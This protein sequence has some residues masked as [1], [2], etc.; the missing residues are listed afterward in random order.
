MGSLPVVSIQR[1][2]GGRLA[3]QLVVPDDLDLQFI[4]RAALSIYW[5]PACLQLEDLYEAETSVRASFQRI[6]GAL[7]SEY[8]LTLERGPHLRW[9][10][11]SNS[12]RIA[13]EAEWSA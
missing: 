5:N 9:E 8:G 11:L 10:G 12:D 3:L 2:A 1:I 13:I 7:K 4:Y 6:A